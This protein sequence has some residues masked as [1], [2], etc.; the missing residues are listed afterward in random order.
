M[1]PVMYSA[2]VTS[3]A[4]FQQFMPF[5]AFPLSI[6]SPAGRSSIS[7]LSPP[8]NSTSNVVKGLA[9]KNSTPISL[10]TIAR[11]N[12]PILLAVSPFAQTRS[13]P[14]TQAS[15]PWLLRYDAAIE[16]HISVPF[17][18]SVTISYAVSRDPWLY[19]LVSS[20]AMLR[21][22]SLLCSSRATPRAVPHPAVAND[23]VLHIVTSRTPSACECR[24][25]RSSAPC[26]PMAMLSDTSLSSM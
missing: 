17:I 3:N 23:P 10:A 22:L 9:T 25:S 2:G 4:G 12:V 11:L 19:G 5:G 21:S 8:S 13:A 1:I 7:I 20:A 26:V 24:E 14:T 18:F 16:S 15:A 6:T